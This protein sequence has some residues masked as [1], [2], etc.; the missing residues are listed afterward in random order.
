MAANEIVDDRK[1]KEAQLMTATTTTT[2]DTASFQE[3]LPPPL[4]ASRRVDNTLGSNAWGSGT[5]NMLVRVSLQEYGGRSDEGVELKMSARR[6][7]ALLA[8][9]SGAPLFIY[10]DIG[11]VDHWVWFVTANLLATAAISPFVGALSDLVGRRYVAIAGSVFIIAGQIVCGTAYTMDIFIGGMALTGIGAGINEITA[12]AG[13]AELVPISQRGYYMAGVILTIVP[14]LPSVLFAQLIASSSTW[15]YIAVLT[16][17][18]AF[19]GVAMTVLFYAPPSPVIAL[20]L[21]GKIGLVKRTDLVGGLL[22]ISGLAAFEI[23]LLGGGYQYSWSSAQALV[24]LVLGVFLLVA[25]VAWE[26]WGTANPMIP[27]RLGKAPRTLVLTLIITFISGANFFSVLMLWPSEAYNVYGHDPIGVGLRGLPF[28][29]GTLAGCVVSLIL[30]SWFRGNIKWL[31][32]GT[33][34]VMT[35]GCGALAALRTDNINTAYAVLFIAGLGVGGI[36][37]PAS[38]ISTIICPSDLIATITALTIAIRIVGGAIGYA[39][40]YNVF[41]NKLVPAL[42]AFVGAACVRAGIT[43]HAVIGK[44]IQLAA[45]SLVDEIHALPGVNDRAWLQI[46]AA[47]QEAYATVYPWVYYCSV[48]FGAVSIIASL[49]MEDITEF[50]DDHVAVV[51]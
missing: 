48:A 47:S 5:A 16:A 8:L 10:R 24:P 13:T 27:R 34:I 18:W 23:G 30:L 20:D 22:S 33:S 32:F 2:Q 12:L 15:R 49:F 50:V 17:G 19:V 43:D 29:F 40:Y 46:V 41:A 6:A 3:P 42:T 35:A 36:V 21:E 4:A 9:A 45:Y 51:L 7:L 39:V 38:T 37:V 28:A 26:I 44:A 11:G 14:F 31:L 1:D 25:F